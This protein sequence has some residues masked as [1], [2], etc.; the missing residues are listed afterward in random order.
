MFFC[1]SQALAFVNGGISNLKLELTGAF[2]FWGGAT[3]EGES[4][5]EAAALC[6]FGCC[7]FKNKRLILVV[8]STACSWVN[9]KPTRHHQ[10]ESLCFFEGCL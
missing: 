5:G 3:P 2:F 9:T 10:E 1:S 8:V 6:C 7:G 4:P